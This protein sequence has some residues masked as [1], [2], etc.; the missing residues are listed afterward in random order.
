MIEPIASSPL[1]EMAPTCAIAVV[2]FVG[3]D[4]ERSPS[5]TQTTALSMPRFRSIGFIPAATA[6]RPSRIIA[7]ASTVAVV[8][9][10]P[11]TSE[12]F[13]ATS[14]T[15]CAPMFSNL[16]SSSISLATDTP[17]LVTVG[18]PKLFSST[19]LRPFGPR[20]TF[21]ALARMLT[22]ADIRARESSLNRTSFAAI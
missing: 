16:S 21:T 19:T 6:F 3:F 12:V 4:S 14:L 18:A 11:A 5:T 17:S 22:P 20:V 1:A 7:C 15:I 13:D 2:S 10:S 9:P 8:V